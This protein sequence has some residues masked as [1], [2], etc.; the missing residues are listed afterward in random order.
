MTLT[1]LNPDYSTDI[2]GLQTDVS[3]L[4]TDV[5][6]KVG[7]T[8]NS[9]VFYARYYVTQGGQRRI[10]F[11]QYPGLTGQLGWINLST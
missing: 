6:R 8:N 7:L 10:Y 9:D 4:Q 5:A 11:Y 2:S 3:G 1:R